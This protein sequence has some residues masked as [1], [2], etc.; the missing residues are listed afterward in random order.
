VKNAVA[1]LENMQPNVG[2]VYVKA[3]IAYALAMA[4]SPLKLNANQDLLNSAR[5]DSGTLYL[6]LND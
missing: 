1:Y 5:Y 6:A 3:V 4:N 2:R